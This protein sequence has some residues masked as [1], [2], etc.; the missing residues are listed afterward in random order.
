MS[1]GATIQRILELSGD[2]PD[3]ER[4][5][6]YLEDMTEAAREQKLRDLETDRLKD[7]SAYARR[8]GHQPK[9]KRTDLFTTHT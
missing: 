5:R 2:M 1:S 3:R 9:T 6:R 4:Y 8:R 7:L